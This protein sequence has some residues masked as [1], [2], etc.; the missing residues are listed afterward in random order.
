MS[1]PTG[2]EVTVEVEPTSASWG[3]PDAVPA[4]ASAD[5]LSGTASA[6]SAADPNDADAHAANGL[7]GSALPA[8]TAAVV[9]DAKEGGAAASTPDGKD[10]GGEVD[11]DDDV[12]RKLRE[13]TLLDRLKEITFEFLPLGYVTFGGPSAHV[14]LMHDLFVKKKHWIGDAQYGELF[15]IAQALPGP[16]STQLAFALAFIRDG[17]LPACWAWLLWTVPGYIV[18]TVL[19]W[20]IASVAET[21]RWLIYLENG[22]VSSAIGLV[23]LA[24]LRLGQGLCKTDIGKILSLASASC[25]IL[26]SSNNVW[27]TPVL[28]VAG[29]LIHWV[30]QRLLVPFGYST[31]L[32]AYRAVKLAVLSPFRGAEVREKEKTKYDAKAKEEVPL[33][34]IKK[35]GAKS[36]AAGSKAGPD[37]STTESYIHAMFSIRT[38]FILLAIWIVLLVVMII[39]RGLQNVDRAVTV[40]ST[41]W[42]TGSIIFGGGPV[43]IPLLESFVVGPGWA[44]QTEFL[45][46][47]AVQNAL[48]GPS[49]F[50]FGA[51]CGALAMRATTASLVAGSLLATVGMFWPALL[52]M[53]SLIPMWNMFR[54]NNEVKVILEG[55]NTSSVGLVYAATYSL[56]NGA[57]TPLNGDGSQRNLP[58]FAFPI[59]TI[60]AAATFVS[61]L[62]TKWSL[63]SPLMVLIGGL[64]GVFQWLAAGRP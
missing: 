33:R 11:F 19:A 42:V 20:A 29:G 64:V 26:W 49:D 27:L 60:L 57:I 23:A 6:L 10:E 52:L 50:N 17:I 22:L 28:I 48:P 45:V 37:K 1:G 56:M 34:E 51:F 8:G 9:V 7:N 16:A 3:D 35:W 15:G 4:S 55:L 32:P 58:L 18:M 63:P 40:M 47:L 61:Q 54:D 43:V 12:H 31:F 38:G 25:T 41:F 36:P 39:V 24:A 13:R 59:Y 21:P 53:A 30:W 44:T 5:A 2:N 62:L 14:A 46:G